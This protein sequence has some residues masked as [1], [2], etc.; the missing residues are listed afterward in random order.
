MQ[1]SPYKKERQAVADCMARLYQTR[2]TTTSGG[3]ISLRLPDGCFCITPSRLDK[4]KLTADLI[5]IVDAEGHNLTPGLP[6]SI[7]SEM[8]RRILLNRPDISVVVHAHP[9]FA[10]T[11][12]AMKSH[13]INTRLTAEAFFLLGEPAFA[14]YHRMGS[15]AL[16][17]AV[18]ASLGQKAVVL[19][20]NH[21]VLTVG[22]TLLEAF[23]LIEVLEQ[24]A[25]MTVITDLMGN[26][27]YAVQ[28]LGE[29]ECDELIDMKSTGKP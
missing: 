27:G 28:A 17:D 25:K 16:A 19:L 23:D 8:H 29:S 6:L 1:D 7:E 4:G 21:G 13:A 2:L 11:F 10:T 9:C 3:N 15:V 18:V 14:P 12:T 24:A 26:A 22:K 5:A 20:E